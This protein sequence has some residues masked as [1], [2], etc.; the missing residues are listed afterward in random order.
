MYTTIKISLLPP[1]V[2]CVLVYRMFR[3]RVVWKTGSVEK[4]STLLEVCVVCWQER[5]KE[6]DSCG[7]SMFCLVL[8]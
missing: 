4:Y 2:V 5:T 1:A 6:I 7:F 8:G 3:K